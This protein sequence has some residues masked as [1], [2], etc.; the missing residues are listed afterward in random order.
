MAILKKDLREGRF[1]RLTKDVGAIPAGVYKLDGMDQDAICFVITDR[2]FIAICGEV[3]HLLEPVPPAQ[4]PLVRTSIKTFIKQYA[5]LLDTR[6]RGEAAFKSDLEQMQIAHT[7][8]LI[9]PSLQSVLDS[10]M[11]E[12]GD[13]FEFEDSLA[14]SQAID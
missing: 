2:V 3:A 7:M 14:Q 13:R 5:Q 8:C 12:L 11:S 9:D 1:Y 4:L 6:R 10:T